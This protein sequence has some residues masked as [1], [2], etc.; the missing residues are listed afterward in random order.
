MPRSRGQ[1][2][3]RLRESN[4]WTLAHVA[5]KIHVDKTALSKYEND[6]RT[7]PEPTL[8][9]LAS[10]YDIELS[11]LLD[12]GTTQKT[13]VEYRLKT[14][15]VL[16][17]TRQTAVLIAVALGSAAFFMWTTVDF[18]LLVSVFFI[19]AIIIRALW[20]T[21]FGRVRPE[22]V[23][24]VHEGETLYLEHPSSVDTIRR[25]RSQELLLL[26]WLLFALALLFIMI[27]P[28]LENA[29]D[30]TLWG[31]AFFAHLLWLGVQTVRV[32]TKRTE[33]QSLIYDRTD[34]F[35]GT[36]PIRLYH[37]LATP[38]ALAIMA[39]YPLISEM[40]NTTARVA[41]NVLIIAY[42]L[43]SQAYVFDKIHFAKGYR[44]AK[45]VDKTSTS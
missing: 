24:K 43:V 41:F 34:R 33:R 31:L 12:L 23:I 39:G 26:P 38:T 8:K 21:A 11:T 13:A 27:T 18:A 40:L 25:R 10:L 32:I 20:T 37:L 16:G 28:A 44:L 45:G 7:V 6:K 35:L 30:Q 1:R 29:L 42:A 22:H 17:H 2:L 5:S 9:A 36:L 3:K 15:L 14:P 4:G 19:T